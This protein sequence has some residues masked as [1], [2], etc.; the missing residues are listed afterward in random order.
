MNFDGE[1]KNRWQG[2]WHKYLSWLWKKASPVIQCEFLVPVSSF[3]QLCSP[4][5]NKAPL[6]LD[7]VV[8]IIF[9]IT[10]KAEKNGS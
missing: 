8:R 9:V 1:R 2:I 6:F 4:A 3:M 7:I 5:L 10:D